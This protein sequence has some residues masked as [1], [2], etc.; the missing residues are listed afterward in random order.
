MPEQ[1]IEC[2]R[3][4]VEGDTDGYEILGWQEN[5]RRVLSAAIK[6][7]TPKAKASAT[8]LINRLVARGYSGFK[9][10]LDSGYRSLT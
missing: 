10:L 6:S 2:M 4:L 3:L 1:C 5:G 9:D 7:G 8:A